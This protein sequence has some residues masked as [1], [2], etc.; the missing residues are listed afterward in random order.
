MART[1]IGLTAVL[2]AASAQQP[3]GA[4]TAPGTPPGSWT[5]EIAGAAPAPIGFA[6]A[7]G[8]TFVPSAFSELGYDSNPNLSLGAP[9]GSAFERTGAGF[10]LSSVS[11]SLM[12]TLSASGSVLDY[13]NDAAFADNVRFAGAASANF[14]YLVQPGVTVSSGAFI[15]SDGQSANKSQT[16]GANVEFGYR[17]GLIANMLRLRFSDVEYLNNAGAIATPL[18]LNSA[19]NYNRSEGAWSGLLGTA[20]PAAPY[21]EANAARVDYT[22]QPAAL[23]VNRSADDY[24]E[25]AGVRLA[26]SPALSSDL[27]WRFNQ[28]DTDDRRIGSY[29]SNFFDGSITWRPSPVFFFNAAAERT[30]GEA[31][32]PLGVLADIRSYSA[33]ANYLPVPGVTLSAAGGW[34][35]VNDIGSGAHYDVNFADA[36]LAWDYSNHM[37]FFTALHYQTYAL[38]GQEAGYDDMRFMTGVRIVPDGQDLLHGESL[39]SL[40]A[41]LADSSIPL[42]S[43]LSVSAGYSRFGLPD[44]KLVTIVGGPFFN[45]ALGQQNNGDGNLNGLRTDARLANFAEGAL[46]SGRPISFGVSGFFANYQGTTNSHCEY[47][48]STDCAIVNI[49]DANAALPNNTGPFGNLNVTARRDVNYYGFALDARL[50]DWT[51]G[52]LKDG[53]PLQELSP[54]RLGLA[55]R[56]LSETANLTSIDPQVGAPVKYKESLNTHYYGGFAG[57]DKKEA[58][59]DGWTASVDATAGLYYTDT[60]YQG[61]YSGYTAIVPIGYFD[62]SGA[63]SANLD[64]GSF[65]GTLRLDLKRQLGWG[66][67]GVFVQGEYLSYVPRIAYN[68]NDQATGVPWGGL[69][70]TQNGTRLL[71]ADAFN[72]TTGLSLSVPVN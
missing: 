63:A 58:L 18:V 60:A 9:K 13:F 32:T 7:P 29:Q 36:Q 68:N 27:G 3:A 52:G 50:A 42:G 46:P 49:I 24:H 11:P 6:V 54:F 45:E 34:Q 69:T 14:T 51:A 16:D 15:V 4:Q 5:A 71:S 57:V 12:S 33:K 64:K 35:A 38:Q 44:M 56:G 40:M 8:A 61:R 26:L 43:E 22:D 59:G 53:A 21:A 17:D 70:G 25:K 72:A 20:W 23:P 66:M 39:E 1:L 67:F 37:Q 31:T 2:A 55:M 28:R 41:R 47:S 48:L 62:D 10:M 65:I 30:I 19:Y